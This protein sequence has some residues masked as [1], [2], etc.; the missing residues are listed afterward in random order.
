MFPVPGHCF[1]VTQVLIVST[2]TV[3]L[4]S[5]FLPHASAYLWLLPFHVFYLLTVSM[6]LGF[7]ATISLSEWTLL[8]PK[9]YWIGSQLTC[10]SL[11]VSHQPMSQSI[12][13]G[14]HQYGRG[15]GVTGYRIETKNK[16]LS[17]SAFP[18]KETWAWQALFFF[19]LI[20][21]Y[22]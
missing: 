12:N 9:V 16:E 15:S 6:S 10:G 1:I 21:V 20:F 8:S 14:S 18:I 3:F 2:F 4:L 7:C 13:P 11:W 17:A 22:F 19:F 5:Y